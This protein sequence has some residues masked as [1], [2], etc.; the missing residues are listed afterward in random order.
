MLK[1]VLT[2]Q[3]V[4]LLVYGI[5]YLLA[6]RF[7][8]VLTQQLPL[9]ENYILRSLGIA[10]VVLAVLE[11]QIARDPERYRGL[12]SAYVLLPALFLVTILLQSFVRGFNGAPWFWML[13]AAV[14]AIF[15]LAVFAARRQA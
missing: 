11:L 10:F 6:P 13:N 9:P 5:P 14:T 15:T 12:V 4:V 7:A 1:G 8:T 3:A 2:V